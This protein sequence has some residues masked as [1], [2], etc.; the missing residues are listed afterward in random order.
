MADYR[1]PSKLDPATLKQRLD[2]KCAKLKNGG[3]QIAD[4]RR[5]VNMT[6]Y[7]IETIDGVAQTPKELARQARAAE[8][9]AA[10]VG[11]WGW[12]ERG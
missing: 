10:K 7:G 2:T 8:R 6:Q 12:R 4:H 3:Q 5:V 9:E 1:D 11:E